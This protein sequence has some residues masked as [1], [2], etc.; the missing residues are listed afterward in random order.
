MKIEFSELDYSYGA[1]RE[2][3]NGTW[4]FP[5]LGMPKFPNL[6]KEAEVGYDIC[7]ENELF[8]PVFIQYKLPRKLI[9]ETAREWDIFQRPY[10]RFMIYPHHV[11]PQHNILVDLSLQQDFVFYLS[12]AFASYEEYC[13]HFADRTI[14]DNSIFIPCNLLPEVGYEYHYITYTDALSGFYW[15]S[16]PE[17]YGSAFTGTTGLVN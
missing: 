6:R 15:C 17:Y 4:L 11:S 5:P 8:A 1:S 3:E 2:F 16:E 13:N 10:Y 12:P 7:F 9:R 14:T